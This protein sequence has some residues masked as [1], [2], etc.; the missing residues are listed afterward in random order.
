MS[1]VTP[2]MV[3]HTKG[4]QQQQAASRHLP[5]YNF[6][7][8][9]WADCSDKSASAV[10]SNNDT[11]TLHPHTHS[12]ANDRLTQTAELCRAQLR[13]FLAKHLSNGTHTADTCLSRRGQLL[14]SDP[15]TLQHIHTTRSRLGNPSPQLCVTVQQLLYILYTHDSCHIQTAMLSC[16]SV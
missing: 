13:H 4:P 15:A 1:S 8:L 16:C 10:T 2:Q 9:R 7:H 14:R 6:S 11:S 3:T 5:H 12:K